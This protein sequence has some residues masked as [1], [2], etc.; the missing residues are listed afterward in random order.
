MLTEEQVRPLLCYDELI[1]VI[2]KALMDF[3]AGRVHQPLRNIIPVPAHGGWFG[4]MPAVYGT[5]MGAKMVAFYPG[6]VNLQKH[7]HMAMIQLFRADTGEPLVTMDGRLITEMRTAAVSAVAIDYLAAPEAKVLAILGSG[8]QA[9]SH[10]RALAGIRSF[11]EVRVWSRSEDHARQFASEVGARVTTAEQAVSGADVVLALT[12]SPQPILMGRWLSPHAMVCAIG[13]ATP[14][15]R[16]LDEEAM[17]GAVVVE[18]REA[19]REEAGDIV[20]AN[21]QVS[22]EI[23]ELL[24]GA[25]WNRGD[26]PVVFKSVGIAVEDIAAAQLVYDKFTAQMGR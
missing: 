19:A 12:S 8:V 11:T 21:A 16:E 10:M 1:P 9:R 4:V 2:R 13:A 25:Q 23:G 20:L 22:A 5:V 7:T 15:R 6:N 3:S 26:R 24:N 17:R 18:S 14:D